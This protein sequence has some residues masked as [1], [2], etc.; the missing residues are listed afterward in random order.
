MSHYSLHRNEAF[1]TAIEEPVLTSAAVTDPLTPLLANTIFFD[2][3]K[4]DPNSLTSHPSTALQA[5]TVSA[6]VMLLRSL[7]HFILTFFP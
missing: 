2:R 4:M 6:L 1:R 5:K 7:L 3:N